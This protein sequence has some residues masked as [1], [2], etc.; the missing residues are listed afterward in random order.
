MPTHPF[1]FRSTIA[2]S[3]SCLLLCFGGC[4]TVAN[5]RANGQHDPYVE[6]KENFIR[7]RDLDPSTKPPQRKTV[8]GGVRYDMYLNEIYSHG[9]DVY[10]IYGWIALCDVPLSFVADTVALPVTLLSQSSTRSESDS[11]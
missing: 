10:P 3:A 5:L 1:S 11:E 8:Y 2:W 7:F 9:S 4:G 6:G